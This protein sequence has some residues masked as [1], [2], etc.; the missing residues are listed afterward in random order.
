MNLSTHLYICMYIY[1]NIPDNKVTF[2]IVVDRV[3][4]DDAQ[5]DPIYMYTHICR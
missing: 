5:L 2:S 3:A 1:I 4:Q